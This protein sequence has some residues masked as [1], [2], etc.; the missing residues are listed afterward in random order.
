MRTR[1]DREVGEFE[2]NARQSRHDAVKLDIA[3]GDGSDGAGCLHAPTSL[4]SV[5]SSWTE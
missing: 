4:Q 1:A 2:A 3:E 5:Q